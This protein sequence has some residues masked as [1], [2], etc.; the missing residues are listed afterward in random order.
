MNKF[1]TRLVLRV[2]LGSLAVLLLAFGIFIWRTMNG[3]VSL[4]LLTP[5]LEG[6]INA[7]LKGIQLRLDDSI[8]EWSE[9]RKFAHLQFLGVKVVDGNEAVIARVPRANITLSG[10]ALLSGSVAPTNVELIGVSATVVRRSGGGLQLGLQMNPASRSD[11]EVSNDA[12]S[13][14]MVRTVLQA[15]LQP[16]QQDTLSLYLKRFA[17][18]DAKLSIFDE[19]TKSYWSAD[20]AT[21]VFDRKPDGV[22]LTVIAPVKLANGT[23]WKFRAAG[24]YTNGSSEIAL[25][26]AFDPVRLR[27]LAEKGAGLQ[28]FKGFDVPVQGNASCNMNISGSLVRCRMWLNAGTGELQ[29]PALKKEP[30]HF[31]EAALTVEMDFL[32]NRYAIEELTWA[33]NSI[34]GSISGDGAFK[35]SGDGAIQYLSADWTA[36]NV[37]IDAPNLFDGGLALETAKFKGSFDATSN[38]LTIE[39]ILARKGPFELTMSGSLQDNPVSI[40]VALSGT[41]KELAIP[42][43]KRLWPAGTVVG[44]RDWIFANIHEGTIR[45]ADI[46]VN[47]APG[48]IVDDRIPD[49][50]MN[51]DLQMAGLRVTYLSG[52]PDMTQV[53]GHAVLKGDSF[54]AQM[55]SA[56]IGALALK[57]GEVQINE[58]HKHG[59]IGRVSGLVVGPTRDALM[60]IDQP[61]LHYPSRYGIQAARAGGNSTIDFAFAIPM[62]KDLN[63]DNIGID[64]DATLA[65]VTL[66][67][68]PKIGITGGKFSVKLG[69]KGL[70]ALGAVKLNGANV[71]FIWNEDFSGTAK[72]GTHIDVTATLSETQRDVFGLNAS[73]YLEGRTAIIATFTGNHGKIQSATID[74][75][76]T[77]SRLSIPELN[78]A[79][80]EDS[81]ASLKALVAFRPDSSI[82]I[83]SIDASGKD[84]RAQGKLVLAGSSVTQAEFKR[85]ELG[86]KNDFSMLMQTAGDH[87]RTI[88]LKGKSL[89]VGGLFE[90]ASNEEPSQKTEAAIVQPLAIKADMGAVNLQ[91]GVVLTSVR[92]AYADDG[93]HLTQF[94]LDAVDQA[95]RVKG[96]LA[97]APDGGRKFRFE[98]VDAGRLVKGVTGFRS[99]L[100]GNLKLTADLTPLSEGVK[101]DGAFDA[102]LTVDDFKIVDQ[103]FFTRLLSAG[104]FTGLDDLMRGEGITFSRLEQTIHGR[105][106]LFTF[107][108]GRAAG[109]SIGLTMQGTWARDASKL[110]LNGTIVPLYGI[111]SIFEGIPLVS[112]LLGSK[113]GEGIFAVTYG[114]RGPVDELKV[115]VNP[116]SMLTPGFLRRIFQVGAKPQPA[117]PM[118]LP[119]PKQEQKSS[120]LPGVNLP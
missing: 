78:W 45:S 41:A 91:A 65:E 75:N 74:A 3:P 50:M 105:G 97:T 114:V 111:N 48:A 53:N 16:N 24:R 99:L 33:G 22:V 66:P 29:L 55:T 70:K 103:P 47:L 7:G 116:I 10:P 57:K 11:G 68:T 109:P 80:P 20:K 81:G 21:L 39:Q 18:S 90:S 32:S 119:M 1:P 5:R 95:A 59:T 28:A 46:K 52:L 61:R 62:L 102:K 9:G 2:A 112:D 73:P 30:I 60:L 85:V 4:G 37:S 101:S 82:E 63:A 51:I 15:M 120:L 23:V 88:E 64:V 96:E 40:G 84:F 19:D 17:I 69:A 104:S 72:F 31:R 77:G 14:A 100:G 113:D 83:S 25:E 12:N 38:T 43:L 13:Q 34:R 8:L 49:E 107:S 27:S 71:G 108:D 115:A 87:T 79:K 42:D 76:L 118:P 36:Q 93:I 106:K 94:K 6:M 58:L 54:H 86:R 110:D 26:A 67:V 117:A 92:L 89:D 35:F 98:T 44:A 56:S